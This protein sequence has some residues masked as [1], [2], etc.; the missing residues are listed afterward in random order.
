MDLGWTPHRPEPLAIHS[1][2]AE[3]LH[4][5]WSIWCNRPWIPRRSESASSMSVVMTSVASPC[6]AGTSANVWDGSST[7]GGGGTCVRRLSLS[8]VEDCSPQ[9]THLLHIVWQNGCRI[10][11]M[12]NLNSSNICK[13][14]CSS[15]SNLTT[16]SRAATTA[17]RTFSKRQAARVQ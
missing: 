5:P 6:W 11:W 2:T 10:H 8:L 12:T 14:S 4:N 1:W 13:P 3:S 16:A 7:A 17:A 9:Q 15:A